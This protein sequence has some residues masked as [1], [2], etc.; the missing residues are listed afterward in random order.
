[1]SF[2]PFGPGSARSIISGRKSWAILALAALGLSSPVG[3]D[4]LASSHREAPGISNDPSADNTDTYVFVSPMRPDHLVFVGCW[5]P[6]GDPAGGPNWF[7]FDPTADYVFHVD[8]DGDSREELTFV[9]RFRTEVANPNTFLYATNTIDSLDDPDWNYRQYYDVLRVEGVL[10]QTTTL[11]E[12]LVVP[13]ANIG[14]RTTPNYESL[15][16]DSFYELD[17][18]IRVFAGQRDDPFFVDLGAV[19]D[20]LGF[21]SVPGNMG[22][23]RDDLAGTN[24]QAIVLEVPIEMVTRDGSIPTDPADAA[25]VIGTW[26]T[27]RR[28]APPGSPIGGLRQVS[29]LGMPLVNEVVIPLGQKDRF[30][31]SVPA[32]DGQFLDYVQN[33]ELPGIIEALYGV[34]APP[35]PRCDIV[36]AF[37]TGVP[38]LNQPPNVV[39]SE[40]LRVNVAIG[41]DEENSRFGVL[42]GDLDGFPNGRRLFDDV[43]DIEERVVAGVLYPAFCDPNFEPHPLASQLGDGV[44][45]NDVPFLGDFPYLATPHQGWEHDH[46][47]IEPAHG[48]ELLRAVGRKAL[49]ARTSTNAAAPGLSLEPTAPI[50]GRD[51]SIAFDLPEAADARLALYD[52]RGRLVREL[53]DGPLAEGS[54]VVSW[55]GRDARGVRVANGIYFSRLEAGGQSADS[56][57]VLVRK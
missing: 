57:L 46:H 44:D 52:V 29:R 51:A 7:H 48:P 14:P 47:R 12:H 36:A 9:F 10:G 23:G 6:F 37:L 35:A 39:P 13:P 45:Q 54:H 2:Q 56:K 33:P 32:N 5:W 34:T 27:T 28:S 20:L 42:A 24:V 25:A 16:A 3:S 55:D 49:D 1:M 38:G 19:F 17:N 11:A 31:A 22:Q 8:N 15:V 26:A 18:G 40:M 43:V 21:R 50:L 4:V 53:V 41:P 30:N